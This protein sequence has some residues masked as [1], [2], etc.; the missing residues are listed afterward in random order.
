MLL[1]ARVPLNKQ[2][3]ERF[4][5]G[6]PKHCGLLLWRVKTLDNQRPLNLFPPLQCRM[7]SNYYSYTLLDSTRFSSG[8]DSWDRNTAQ[9]DS[10][11]SSSK[12]SIQHEMKIWFQNSFDCLYHWNTYLEPSILPLTNKA[13]GE[14]KDP[15]P[16]TTVWKL[17]RKE[18]TVPQLIS[19]GH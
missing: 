18:P 5:F 14:K 10:S 1:L 6:T 11:Y 4:S 8:K 2:D 13:G 16:S 9:T 19:N 7:L 12:V 3:S 17:S 15:L